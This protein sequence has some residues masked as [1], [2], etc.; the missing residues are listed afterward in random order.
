M[1]HKPDPFYSLEDKH[2][3]KKCYC[4]CAFFADAEQEICGN[5]NSNRIATEFPI[6]EKSFDGAGDVEDVGRHLN[7][8]LVE[9]ESCGQPVPGG[10]F[11]RI[12]KCVGE[13]IKNKRIP[14]YKKKLRYCGRFAGYGSA[15]SSINSMYQ[16]CRTT[17][18][19]NSKYKGKYYPFSWLE[20]AIRF[21][22]KP[23]DTTIIV[24]LHPSGFVLPKN[25]VG[26]Y[27]IFLFRIILIRFCFNLAEVHL[28]NPEKICRNR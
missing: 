6:G 17:K 19:D 7:I 4:F 14:G 2:S 22:H 23:G 9:R 16:F 28:V 3:C 8:L 26:F 15:T 12:D 27:I 18:N 21:Y 24:M 25:I 5:Y 10:T 11:K 13:S 1:Y 20:D